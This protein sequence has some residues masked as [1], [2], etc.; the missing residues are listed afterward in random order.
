MTKPLSILISNELFPRFQA[1][2]YSINNLKRTP[3][4]EEMDLSVKRIKTDSPM[5]NSSKQMT[6]ITPVPIV[7]S[8]IPLIKSEVIKKEVLDATE[9]ER[10]SPNSDSN[11]SSDSGRLQMD[12]SSQEDAE[13]NRSFSNMNRIERGTPESTF[14]EEQTY[15]NPDVAQIWQT[16]MNHSSSKI[17]FV[18]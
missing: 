6:T 10:M 1:Q 4:C 12:I 3:S 2:D 5:K 18:C 8:M 16:V 14:S 15:D 7:P 9:H 13:E 11:D 17:N